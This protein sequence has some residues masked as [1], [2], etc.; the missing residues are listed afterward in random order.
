MK[1]KNCPIC[2]SQVNM[3]QNDKMFL[4]T[5]INQCFVE[6]SIWANSSI[7]AIGFFNHRTME[8]IDPKLKINLKK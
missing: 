2:Q 7:E 6:A 1:I 5:C 8:V 4:F 3:E